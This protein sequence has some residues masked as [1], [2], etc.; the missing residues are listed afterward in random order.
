MVENNEVEDV[1]SNGADDS[2]KPKRRYFRTKNKF[3]KKPKRKKKYKRKSKVEKRGKY[4][5]V[6]KP[7][8]PIKPWR[9][10]HTAQRK[11]KKLLAE[12][13]TK[14][15]ALRF[16]TETVNI[17]KNTVRFPVRELVIK[18][19]RLP[20]LSELVLL[21]Y[22]PNNEDNTSMLRDEIGKFVPHKVE[23]EQWSIYAKEEYLTE[24]SF[25]VYGYDYL[26]DRKDFYFIYNELLI[27]GRRYEKTISKRV[28]VYANKL[29]IEGDFD[30]DVV[31]TKSKES[32]QEN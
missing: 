2:V 31:I 16:F 7:P 24:E 26:K 6:K 23:Q 18:H 22:I 20:G 3:D 8:P 29:V 25:Y 14:E 17:A 19:S 13:S 21:H 32:K 15:D 27:D 28:W 12:F 1:G 30:F 5:R 4:K 10:I 11:R 9:I